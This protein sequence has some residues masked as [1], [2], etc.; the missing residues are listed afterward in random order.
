MGVKDG[1]GRG[2][3][4]ALSLFDGSQKARNKKKTKNKKKKKKKKKFCEALTVSSQEK[5]GEKKSDGASFLSFCFV[6]LS[7][8]PFWRPGAVDFLH[9]EKKNSTTERKKFFPL[10]SLLLFVS[11]HTHPSFPLPLRL[12]PS[13]QVAHPPFHPLG[14]GSRLC[15]PHA[16]DVGHGGDEDLF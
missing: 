1:L 11:L 4:G 14:A 16:D 10:L 3:R 12:D 15:G 6:S 5:K 9:L 7:C 8:P 13:Q 2:E